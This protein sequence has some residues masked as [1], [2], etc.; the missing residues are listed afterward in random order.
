[1]RS[2]WVH[3]SPA[4]LQTGANCGATPRRDCRCTHPGS[5]GAGHDHL[6]DLEWVNTHVPDRI[7]SPGG[8]TTVL[9][10]AQLEL[11][12]AVLNWLDYQEGRLDNRRW[13]ATHND[14]KIAARIFSDLAEARGPAPGDDVI[15]AVQAIHNCTPEQALEHIRADVEAVRSTRRNPRTPHDVVVTNTSGLTCCKV[16]GSAVEPDGNGFSHVI[17]SDIS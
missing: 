6:V 5:N 14:L 9:E 10:Q 16:C 11:N 4:L 13:E 8:T 2:V 15:R 3:C 1:M 17:W 12:E 7:I